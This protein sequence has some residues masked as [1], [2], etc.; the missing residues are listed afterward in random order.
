[1][2]PVL[3]P[4]QINRVFRFGVFELH[5]RSGELRKNGELVRLQQQP[6]RVLIALLEYSGEV[7][8][9]EEIRERVWSDDSIQDFDNSL[10]V[11]IN[12]LRQ[13]LGDDPEEPQFIATVPRRGYRWL[14]PVTVHESPP[15]A[16][17]TP[18]ELED[19]PTA[20]LAIDVLPSKE[21]KQG[22]GLGKI[23]STAFLLL[24]VI[25]AAKYLRN[26]KPVEE[27][28][29]VPLT[30][31]PGLEYMPSISP[32]GTR[33]AFAWTGNNPT[34]PYSVYVKAIGGEHAQRLAQPPAGASDGDPV[35]SPDGK[36][37]YFARRGSGQ[38]GLF[39]VPAEGGAAQM[40]I[41]TSMSN[42]RLRRDRF[43]VSPDGKSL[44]YPDEIPGKETVALFVLDLATKQSRQITWPPSNSEGDGDPAYSHDGKTIAIHRNTFD[45][46][47]VFLVGAEGGEPRFL[48]SNFETDFIDGLCWTGD[49]RDIIFGG[50]QLRRVS[51]AS[52]DPVVSNIMFVP[53]PSTFPAQRGNLIAYVQAAVNANIWKLDLRD[54]THAKGDPV[55]LISSTRQQAAAS[56]SP[57]GSRIAFQSDRSGYWEI[58]T[59]NRDGS[60]PEQ[61]THFG[62]PLA[63]TPRWSPDGKKIAFDSRASGIA[64]IYVLPANGGA[65]QRITNDPDGGEVPS[66]SRDGKWIYY[67]ANHKGIQDIW[68]MP[69]AGGTSNAVTNNG[70]I[71]GAESPDGKYLYFSRS[72]HDPTIWRIPV[73]GGREEQLKSVPRPFDCSHWVVVPGGIYL[74]DSNGD[75][76]F[77]QA[78]KDKAT[79]ILHDQ[80]FITD[81][82]MAISPDG[83]ELVWAQIDDRSADLMLVENLH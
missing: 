80:R 10:R 82:S 79:K 77:Y 5:V 17:E 41:P 75:L 78:T 76:L 29:V 16:L 4:S 30:S 15:V 83:R 58:W 25:G 11:A 70:G 53:G 61:L 47:Q 13:A 2:P 45:R 32:D 6:L 38:T 35:W 64:Q 59:C 52:D 50:K 24:I 67:T 69:V 44:V 55:K 33:V 51:T 27:S 28:K 7:I 43:D 42:R 46:E 72:S 62:G 18:N 31:Y 73:E 21:P 3:P 48:M 12:K 65:A 20:G 60:E 23:L 63:G 68:R 1:M 66:W 36:F 81:W 54:A 19:D 56:Y 14:H 40:V 39:V 37:V 9:R 71:Y 57:D 26:S 49:D 34:D 8:T 74:V 22:V